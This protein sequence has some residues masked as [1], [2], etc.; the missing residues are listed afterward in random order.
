MYHAKFISCKSCAKS[1][2]KVI[3]LCSVELVSKVFGNDGKKQHYKMKFLLKCCTSQSDRV[4][5]QTK[6]KKKNPT[7]VT[8]NNLNKGQLQI[9]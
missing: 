4:K 1:I 5:K 9:P 8:I 3:F 6:T 2:F 7:A